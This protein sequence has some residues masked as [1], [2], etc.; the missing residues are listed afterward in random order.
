MVVLGGAITW[1]LDMSVAPV[2]GVYARFVLGPSLDNSDL[3]FA[4]PTDELLPAWIAGLVAASIIAG[5]M[6]APYSQMMGPTTLIATE[7]DQMF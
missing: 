2:L 3:A 6:S 7:F 4:L 5:S 1:P